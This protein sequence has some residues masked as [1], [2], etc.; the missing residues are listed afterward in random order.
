MIKHNLIQI[1][2]QLSENERKLLSLKL[3][4]LLK[5]NTLNS[6]SD[7]GKKLVAYI[8]NNDILDIDHLKTHIKGQLPDYMIPTSFWEVE[9]IP[10]L[11]NG[12]VDKNKLLKTKNN[13]LKADSNKSSILKPKTE[14]EEKLLKIWEEVLGFSPIST[15]DNFFEIGGDSILSIQIL[16]KARKVGI[17]LKANQIF[18]NQTIAELA[19]FSKKNKPK[20]ITEP[21]ITG[22]VSLTPIQHWFFETHKIAP[23]FWNQITEIKNIS[24]TISSNQIES[25][26]TKLVFHHDTL[27]SSFTLKDEIWKAYILNPESIKPF[28]SISL[29][30]IESK[31]TQDSEIQKTI[32]T[33]QNNFKLSDGG[34]F[35][36]LYFNCKKIQENRIFI[37]AHHLII[38]FVSWNII[39][40]DI[41][42]ALKQI[43]NNK[44][45]TFNKKT[46][47]I[48]KWG[49][50]LKAL[51]N[52][53]Q[54]QNELEFWLS[55]KKDLK[56][57]PV[58][59][60]IN[61]NV[62][63]EKSIVNYTSII[64]KKGT[65]TLL[66]KGNELYNT[67]IEDL[68]ITA[69]SKTLFEW[70]NMEHICLG[71][72]RQGRALDDDTIDISN[73][74]GWF[75]SY[76][77]VTL[78][79]N[80]VDDIGEKIKSVKEQ[81]NAIPNNGIGYTI[82]KYL[83]NKNK[84][85]LDINPKVIFNY[86]GNTNDT[87]DNSKINFQFL[88]HG[89]R[90]QLSERTYQIELN[91]YVKNGKLNINWSYTKALYKEITF[92]KLANA[93]E[94]NLNELITYCNKK[95]SG[96]YT[97]SDF[98]ESGLNQE[99]LDSLMNLF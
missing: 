29:Q 92:I 87:L 16:S 48:K 9:K 64:D 33:I 10:L 98:P 4:D 73:T 86:L 37:I 65:T 28:E 71:L 59:F 25:I 5:E 31:N 80:N 12:K 50:Y 27:R 99:D 69:L 20:N 6:S 2:E 36:I 54:I 30:S 70:A 13:S 67:K 7:K 22:E 62:Y 55:Q 96:E 11:P 94:T 57:F 44:E 91:T 43:E 89:T 42:F 74:V 18:E 45:I 93:F 81:L 23:H 39:F 68:L 41:Q 17:E 85:D 95:E 47:S 34:L 3:T 19:L 21:I 14:I 24:N 77:P 63:N 82:I 46:D 38:D 51:V 90:S 60:K 53:K 52:S 8:K 61:S 83:T 15:N 1:L 66:F 49:E 58:D 75:T 84:T 97:P 40:H 56:Q 76:F 72:E 79:N 32:E 78:E 35:K 26:A 88:S